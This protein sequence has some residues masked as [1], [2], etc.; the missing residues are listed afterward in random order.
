VGIATRPPIKSVSLSGQ[1]NGHSDGNESNSV[2]SSDK[3]SHGM[4]RTLTRTIPVRSSKHT[5]FVDITDEVAQAVASSGVSDGF[6]VVYSRHTT[7]RIHINEHEPL[8]LQDLGLLLERLVPR[9]AFYHHDD[10][11]V[12]TVN[13]TPGERVNGHSHCRGLFIGA[14]EH[15]PVT[16]GMMML[17]RWQRVFMV[18]L[19]G[20]QTREVAVKVVGV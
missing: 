13:L 18:E 10:F 14:S 17:G 20:P 2:A 9:D 1:A 11:S 15:I 3:I 4:M 7:S 16:D 6:V 5:Q 8:L 19:D 12:R